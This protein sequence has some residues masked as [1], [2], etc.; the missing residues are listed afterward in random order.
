MPQAIIYCDRCGKIIPP[1]EQGR[2]QAIVGDEGG[3][4]PSCAATLTPE[5]RDEL[6]LKLTGQAPAAQPPHAPRSS[7]TTAKRHR[8]STRTT[9][10]P[11]RRPTPRAGTG[12]PSPSWAPWRG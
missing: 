10:A 1:G 12:S 11:H 7:R 8:M 9:A 3:I 6:R 2:G 5:Q 4:C